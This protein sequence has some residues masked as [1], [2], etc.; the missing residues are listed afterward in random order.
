MASYHHEVGVT[1]LVLDRLALQKHRTLLSLL[2]LLDDWKLFDHTLWCE[3]SACVGPAR[4][5]MYA[6]VYVYVLSK[7]AYACV[8]VCECVRERVRVCV[9]TCGGAV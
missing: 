1:K 6:R 3:R 8:Y 7:Y 5:H 4:A 9:V 2:R